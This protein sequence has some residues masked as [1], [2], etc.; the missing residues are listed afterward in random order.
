QRSM[1]ADL[2]RVAPNLQPLA[3]GR[4]FK[5]A[6]LSVGATD[7]ERA[8]SPRP[9]TVIVR[10]KAFGV[11]HVFGATRPD[12]EFGSGYAA[13]ED[14]LFMMDVF[15]HVGRSQLSSFLGPSQTALALDCEVAR[16]AGYTETELQAQIDALPRVY[17]QPFDATHTEGQ[18]VVADGT[19]YID[20]VNT[21]IRQALAN[22]ALL[23]AEYPALQEAP[24][25]FK[26]TDIIA[27]A[28]LVQAIFAVG[29]GG[30]VD[31]ALFY[32]SLVQRY[33][34]AE[35]TALW[36]DLRSQND[37]GAQLTIP[38][39]FPYMGVPASID[40]NSL[41]LPVSQPSTTMCDGGPL[42]AA[43]PGLGLISVAGLTFDLR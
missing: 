4:Y 10:D 5:Q 15:R 14:R 23:P 35:G 31:S 27:I 28:T 36:R 43:N 39:A 9:G 17:T 22:P 19:A 26:P 11:P 7:V 1:Y 42:P 8:Y 32:Q 37:P 12:T 34:A 24:V 6:G 20:G 30:E 16:V 29:G 21:Y 33:G 18:Q 3:V 41:A 13:A 25:P 40:P 2:V 38:T